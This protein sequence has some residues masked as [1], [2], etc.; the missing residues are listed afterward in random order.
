MGWRRQNPSAGRTGATRFG[1]GAGAVTPPPLGGA[2]QVLSEPS[3]CRCALPAGTVDRRPEDFAEACA[4]IRRAKLGH[5]A[6]FFVDFLGLD[7]QRDL[8]GGAIDRGDLGVDLLAD[9]KPVRALLAAVARQLG[10]ADKAQHS[11]ADRDLDAALGDAGNRAGYHLAS[12]QFGKARL[13]RVGFELFDAEADALLFDI[14]VKH[15]GAHHLALVIG[16]E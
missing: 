6:L 15:L 9:R 5:R 4:R 10:F 13:E 12:A 16:V 3:V 7:R 1:A 11:V 2:P 8:A 14:D